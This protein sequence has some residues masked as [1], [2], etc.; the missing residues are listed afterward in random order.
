MVSLGS[1]RFIHSRGIYFC[2]GIMRAAPG[3]ALTLS[4]VGDLE[5]FKIVSF[6]SGKSIA[7]KYRLYLRIPDLNFNG[8]LFEGFEVDYVSE[9]TLRYLYVLYV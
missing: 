9:K 4:W 6:M 7:F 8:R 1:N 5:H 2:V 3:K